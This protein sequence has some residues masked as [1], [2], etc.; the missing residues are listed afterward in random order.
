MNNIKFIDLEKNN[1]TTKEARSEIIVTNSYGEEF[2]I[3]Y[4]TSKNL[5]VNF[6]TQ[7]NI[8]LSGEGQ[9]YVFPSK[10][11]SSF[12]VELNGELQVYIRNGTKPVY[13]CAYDNC[14][15]NVEDLYND[16]SADGSTLFMYNNSTAKITM[17]LKKLNMYNNTKASTYARFEEA[18][19]FDSTNLTIMKTFI[20]ATAQDN[21]VIEVRGA[22]ETQAGKITVLDNAQ[23]I[24][25]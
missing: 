19:L 14:E 2:L 6:I 9:V 22:L 25:Y 16:T 11:F 7:N 12:T 20:K 15:L 21:S 1:I 8:K 24:E 23:L 5:Q 13:I 10:I 4:K 3:V 18:E 17:P